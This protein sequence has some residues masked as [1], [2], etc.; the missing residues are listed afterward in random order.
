MNLSFHIAK[1]IAFNTEK[2]FS[3]FIIRLSIAAT[4]VSVMAMI[5]TLCFVNGFQETIANKVFSFWGHIR[6]QHFEADKSLISEEV[7]IEKNDTVET[8]LKN[9]KGLERFQTFATKSAVI[10]KNKEIE[11]IL[12]KGINEQYDSSRLKQ[13]IQKGRWLHFNDSSYSREILVSTP[14][15]KQLKLTVGDTVTVYFIS[16]IEAKSTYRKLIIAGIYK[17][18]IEEYDKLFAIGDLALIQRINNWQPNQIGGYE[19]FVKQYKQMDSINNQLLDKLPNVW[20]SRT[21][22]DVYPNI[23]DWLN[24]QDI[25]RN[26]IFVIMAVVAVI[27][28]ITCLLILVLER[29]RMIGILKALGSTNIS[30]QKVFLFYAGFITVSGIFIGLIGG[31]GICWLQ[32]LTGFIT[33]DETNYYVSIAPVHIV[34]WQIILVCT[35][36]ALVCFICLIAPT[37]LVK[38]IQPVKAIQ[39]R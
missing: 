7:A 19:I 32:Q 17:T 21:I 10:Q 34:W 24:I 9:Q 20:N 22:K 11:G 6:V 27:N 35:S 23:F 37:I 25:N 12:F 8:I 29:T 5:V 28:L 15:A 1:K 36:T 33:L 30:I 16:T 4:A 13:F 39:F 38:K 31:L 2:T 18:G 26:I 14:M 3:R